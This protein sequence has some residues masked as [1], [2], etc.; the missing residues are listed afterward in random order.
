MLRG[1]VIKKTIS[2]HINWWFDGN[3]QQHG[4]MNINFIQKNR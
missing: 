2:Q 4:T 3:S 1:K